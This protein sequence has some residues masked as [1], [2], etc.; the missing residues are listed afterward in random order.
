MTPPRPSGEIPSPV[1][2]R[3]MLVALTEALERH[4]AAR[5]RV[6]GRS[7]FPVVWPG[8]NVAIERVASHEYAA[9]DI[10]L[11]ACAASPVLHRVVSRHSDLL[12]VRGDRPGQ[13]DEP[14]SV[15]SVLGRVKGLTLGNR[16]LTFVPASVAR[17]VGRLSAELG[18]WAVGSLPLPRAASRRSSA[19]SRVRIRLMRPQDWGALIA[20]TRR[21]GQANG[22][23][24]LRD[25]LDCGVWLAWVRGQVVGSYSPRW[26]AHGPKPVLHD[27]W[28]RSGLDVQ[29]ALRARWRDTDTS[30]APNSQFSVSML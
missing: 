5:V 15:D 8:S 21:C 3:D 7:M 6:T 2:H 27:R 17:V 14:L 25:A 19:L 29:L 4:G 10:V 26:R 16:N 9:G 18:S 12:L 23:M 20:H 22:E 11:Y 13:V 30:S 28:T 1:S 24:D